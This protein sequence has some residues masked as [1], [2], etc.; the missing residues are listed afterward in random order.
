M[1]QVYSLLGNLT[2][3][4]THHMPHCYSMANNSFCIQISY[5]IMS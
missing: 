1:S 5:L 3:F 2:L 4:A